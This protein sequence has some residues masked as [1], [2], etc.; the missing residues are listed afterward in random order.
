MKKIWI[1][2]ALITTSI[3]GITNTTYSQELN[4]SEII[5]DIDHEGV[6]SGLNLKSGTIG[7]ATDWDT[8]IKLDKANGN[9]VDFWVKNTGIIPITIMINKD[10]DNART[11]EAG[12]EGYITEDVKN[13][14]SIW[15]KTYT[16]TVN[17][18][19]S[20]GKVQFEYSLAQRNLS[21]TEVIPL[22]TEEEVVQVDFSQLLNKVDGR[23][24]NFWVENVSDYAIYID[25]NGKN[26][27]RI[28]A[29]EADY[30]Q[31]D[32]GNIFSADTT[33]CNF[34]VRTAEY[35]YVSVNYKVTQ[36]NVSEK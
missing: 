6:S 35:A 12:E 4:Q 17:P 15:S 32:I 27:T 7:P 11:F 33:A 29:G 31:L 1:L 28:E 23:Y 19:S 2:G 3:I 21:E 24:I 18:P 16:F 5:F 30:V 10:E 34:N 9:Q 22:T 20:G 8:S 13:I 36:S 14:L 25:I 26:K